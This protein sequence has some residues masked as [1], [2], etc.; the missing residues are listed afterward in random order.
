MKKFKEVIKK[1]VNLDKQLHDI[2]SKPSPVYIVDLYSSYFIKLYRAEDKDTAE[3]FMTYLAHNSFAYG[4]DM[5]VGKDILDFLMHEKD[6]DGKD[7]EKMLKALHK[8]V[9]NFKAAT[10]KADELDEMAAETDKYDRR[11]M[12]EEIEENARVVVKW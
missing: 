9:T 10:V 4:G 5:A 1:Q 2:F 6:D 11:G 8:A 7:M 12:L 3:R